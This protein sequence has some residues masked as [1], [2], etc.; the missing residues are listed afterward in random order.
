[1]IENNN[2]KSVKENAED[3]HHNED[4]PDD[5]HIPPDLSIFPTRFYSTSTLAPEGE[6]PFILNK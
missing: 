2:G 1:M 6:I 5:H 3:A 4:H